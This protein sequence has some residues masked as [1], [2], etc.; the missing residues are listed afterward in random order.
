MENGPKD[1]N[2]IHA[3]HCNICGPSRQCAAST[4]CECVKATAQN[5][6]PSEPPDLDLGVQDRIHSAGEAVTNDGEPRPW[7]Y[8]LGNGGD[9]GGLSTTIERAGMIRG[10]ARARDHHPAGAALAPIEQPPIAAVN[11]DGDEFDFDR[12]PHARSVRDNEDSSK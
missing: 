1:S 2:G 12:Y 3:V 4:K 6:Q 8:G 7:G 5:G 9:D 10:L 11:P